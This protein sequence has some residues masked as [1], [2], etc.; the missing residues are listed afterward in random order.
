MLTAIYT[1]ILHKIQL[2]NARYTVS[3]TFQYNVHRINYH[4]TQRTKNAA[5]WRNVKSTNNMTFVIVKSISQIFLQFH[6]SNVFHFLNENY[7]RI[8]KKKSLK[9]MNIFFTL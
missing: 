1:Y 5:K 7:Q 3:D 6:F 2:C 4:I 8:P 9:E